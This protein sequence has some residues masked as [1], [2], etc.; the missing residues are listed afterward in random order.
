MKNVIFKKRHPAD[1]LHNDVGVGFVVRPEVDVGVGRNHH[2]S[3]HSAA[4]GGRASL[5][6]AN[7]MEEEE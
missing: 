2:P 1:V 5:A 3:I 7:R 6:N 4:S